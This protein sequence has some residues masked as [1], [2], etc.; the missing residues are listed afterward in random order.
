[1]AYKCRICGVNEVDNQGDICELCAI[2]QDPYAQSQTPSHSSH[3]ASQPDINSNN[4]NDSYSPKRGANRKVLLNGGT[5]LANQDP[6][7]NDMT[8]SEPQPSVQVYSAGQ[9]P[10][11]SQKSTNTVNSTPVTKMPGNQ[12]ITTG[13]TKNI[14]VDNQKSQC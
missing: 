12:P 1:M 9:V 2:G 13:I 10:Q 14:S 3:I 4:S 6:Y 11:A 5:S 7:G 8:T